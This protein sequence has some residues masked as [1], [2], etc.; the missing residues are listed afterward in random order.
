MKKRVCLFLSLFFLLGFILFVNISCFAQEFIIR[1][2]NSEKIFAVSGNDNGSLN[3]VINN[4][5]AGDNQLIVQNN[6]FSKNLVNPNIND[7]ADSTTASLSYVENSYIVEFNGLSISEKSAQIDDEINKLKAK[8]EL[9]E[10]MFLLQ[11]YGSQISGKE[12]EK[13][14]LGVDYKN[15]L[16]NEHANALFDIQDRIEKSST[17][18]SVSKSVISGKLTAFFRSFLALTG[19][20]ISEPDAP[21]EKEFYN[22]L[23][24]VV[25]N[26]TPQ[27]AEE[28][29]K[30]S[31]V[32]SVIQNRKV[33]SELMNSVPLI[34]AN[35]VW[36]LTDESGR[37]IT[38]ENI[39]I[40]IIDTGIDYTHED[41]GGGNNTYLD[42][43]FSKIN[44]K[45][46]ALEFPQYDQNFDFKDNQVAYYSKNKIY[47]YS[48]DDKNFTEFIPFGENFSIIRMAFENNLIAY[49]ASDETGNV[50]LYFFNTQT[51]QNKKISGISSIGYVFVSNE[52]IIYSNPVGGHTKI[53]IYDPISSNSEILAE[54]S[55]HNLVYPAVNDDI[56]AYSISRV[57]GDCYEKIGV[58][59]I[60]SKEKKYVN[61]TDLGVVFDT[62]G[63]LILFSEC[64]PE[65]FDSQWKT[66]HLY[67]TTNQED[68]TL[69]FPDF[70]SNNSRVES[71]SIGGWTEKGAIGDGVVYFSKDVGANKIVA[72]DLNLTKYSLINL[73]KNS[74]EIHAE[75]KKICFLSGS[76]IYCHD[77]NSSYDYSTPTN[78]FNN[79][80][81]GGHDFVDNDEDP[82]D[83]YG[84]GTHVAG[85]AAGTGNGN[86]KGVAPGALLY[87]YKVLDSSGSGSWGNVIAAI[88]RSVDP[89][90]DGNF[91]DHLDIISLSLGGDG[92]PDD[93][94][95]RA[96][97]NAV[98][99]GVVATISAG[100]SGPGFETIGSPGTSRKAIT[101]GAS[102]D[103]DNL[104]SFSSRGYVK[105]ID[106]NG[107]IN[108]LIKPDV[109]A[110]GVDICS[111]KYGSRWESN[112]CLDNTHVSISGTSMAAPHVA[113]AVAL[114]KQAHPDWSPE[115]IKSQLQNTAKNVKFSGS[116][117]NKEEN[118]FS[119]GYGRIDVFDAVTKETPYLSLEVKTNLDLG[120]LNI[121]PSIIGGNISKYAVYYKRLVFNE[122]KE[123]YSG[124]DINNLERSFNLS[125]LDSGSLLFKLSVED[126]DGNIFYNENFAYLD[127][128]Q[129]SLSSKNGYISSEDETI[130]VN[131]KNGNYQTYEIYVSESDKVNSTFTKVYESENSLV[132]GAIVTVNLGNLNDGK[133][134][135]ELRAKTGS[136]VWVGSIPVSIVIMKNLFGGIIQFSEFQSPSHLSFI[137]SPGFE[138][139]IIFKS[140]NWVPIG[141]GWNRVYPGLEIWN[142]EHRENLITY[143]SSLNKG[144]NSYQVYA[145]KGYGIYSE[146]NDYIVVE[147]AAG[148]Y[149]SEGDRIGII[150]K[151]L[152]YQY[153]WPSNI[154]ESQFDDWLPSPSSSYNSN[155]YS[156]HSYEDSSL[157]DSN[158]SDYFKSQ[159]FNIAVH[160]K[161]G[162]RIGLFSIKSF[163]IEDAPSSYSYSL[164]YPKLLFASEEDSKFGVIYSGNMDYVNDNGENV[165]FKWADFNVFDLNT[166]QLIKS[167]NLSGIIGSDVD[168]ITSAISGDIDNDNKT[169]IILGYKS[170]NRTLYNQNTYDFRIYHA[171]FLI[172]D[173]EGNQ[174]YPLISFE[175]YTLDNEI[176]L[177]EENGKKYIIAPLSGTWATGSIDKL[178]V[179]DLNKN[180]IFNRPVDYY[181]RIGNAISGDI[182]NDNKTEI[183]YFTTSRFW[184]GDSKDSVRTSQVRILDLNNNLKK[185]IK[186]YSKDEFDSIYQIGLYENSGNTWLFSFGCSNDIE[187][188]CKNVSVYG[189]DLGY[190]YNSSKMFWPTLGKNIQ[191]NNCYESGVIKDIISFLNLPSSF[192]VNNSIRVNLS[193]ENSYN[194][195]KNVNYSVYLAKCEFENK[196]E[197]DYV[198]IY[199]GSI[200]IAPNSNYGADLD[201]VVFEEG[202]YIVKTVVSGEE[203]KTKQNYYLFSATKSYISIQGDIYLN[204]KLY[205]NTSNNIR[206]LVEN[207]GNKGA[208]VEVSLYYEKGDCY[209][210]CN[211]LILVGKANLSLRK[212]SYNYLEFEWVPQELGEFSFILVLNATNESL[213]KRVYRTANVFEEGPDALIY[214]DYS[215]YEREYFEGVDSNLSLII[216][217]QGSEDAANLTVSAYEVKY[218]Y[219]KDQK[220]KV[221]YDLISSKQIDKLKVQETRH[222]NLSWIPSSSDYHAISFNITCPKDIDLSNNW[223][224]NYYEVLKNYYD[225]GI[226]E[227]S[228]R[229]SAIIDQPSSILVYAVNLGKKVKNYNLSLYLEGRFI[230]NRIVNTSSYFDGWN[231]FDLTFKNKGKRNIS[232]RIEI[233][234]E[235]F[236]LTNNYLE[237]YPYIYNLTT[238]NLTIKDSSSNLINRV[239]YFENYFSQSIFEI[240]GSKNIT[241]VD[242]SETGE[243]FRF[244]I[245]D[246]YG[247][248]TEND[249]E[250]SFFVLNVFNITF[251]KELEVISEYYDKLD[252]DN[253]T[254]YSVFANK[255][256]S[257]NYNN[258]FY[259]VQ[260]CSYFSGLGMVNFDEDYDV[261]YCSNFDFSSKNC[262]NLWNI[263]RISVIYRSG[264][265]GYCLV[266]AYSTDPAEAFALSLISEKL[267]GATTNLSEINEAEIDNLTFERVAHGNINFKDKVYISRLRGNKALLKSIK[268]APRSISI[269][270]EILSELADIPAEITFKNIIF[271]NPKILYNGG[272]CNSSICGIPIYDKE[273][274]KLT[275]NVSHFSEFEVVEGPYC[276]DG[277]CSN[278]ETCSSCVAD[279]IC[280]PKLK[281]DEVQVGDGSC[282]PKWNCSWSAC[283]NSFQDL[284]CVDLYKCK[285]VPQN[286]LAKKPKG[287]QACILDE[288]CEDNDKDGY[289]T[290]PDCR[291]LDTDDNDPAVHAEIPKK[292]TNAVSNVKT[293]PSEFFYNYRYILIGAGAVITL[294]IITFIFF[295]FFRKRPEEEIF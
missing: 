30:S 137:N 208:K 98:E 222:I 189:I 124:S 223:D 254:Y 162:E 13:E 240:N 250:P 58:Y 109:V 114:I 295:K 215:S 154:K 101:V 283:E 139:N 40:G 248:Y 19:F 141:N 155:I 209:N 161:Y 156:L 274:N 143:G 1:E 37:S 231:D 158:Y 5:S 265:S 94:V 43:D 230:E 192:E 142:K 148:Y 110:P 273:N 293:E 91:S 17:D 133:Y 72:Y 75:G 49:F 245:L 153:S 200:N 134:N 253:H 14:K 166:N 195:N 82:M 172:L 78:V 242:F 257:E 89:N 107:T 54:D 183:I 79:K 159:V 136:G 52:K 3:N 255:A 175:G 275:L 210:N 117:V 241:S 130:Q 220:E 194:L 152:N 184:T 90:Q 219:S 168:Y 205:L 96:I 73:F 201:L 174:K 224:T 169:E 227:I 95:S 284:I 157:D 225:I 70:N 217:N 27:Q 211:N 81:V 80:V 100:N 16:K 118:L 235:D 66:F 186:F 131:V 249:R 288:I 282:V 97:D 76:D 145:P 11:S 294:I 119:I 279:C 127:N 29:K 74:A 179:F 50:A 176:S 34:N 10:R 132:N 246:K 123:L 191:R 221:K 85:I 26:I 263:S 213:V 198:E 99:K 111:S 237:V 252:Y 281:K 92:N 206:V 23:N 2:G 276:G 9:G 171:N 267:D 44:L 290:G 268:I 270:T 93:P 181:E 84:H 38:G 185:D 122:W 20:V 187:G 272:N 42:R 278:S 126:K 115:K 150:D 121:T 6:Q 4:F 218:D 182:D 236:N 60:T 47:I 67:N 196:E 55:E 41:L 61:V 105:W 251:S 128:I 212:E 233:E 140:E 62:D 28:I 25:L 188:Q 167:V 289:G 269:D 68:V 280:Q 229:G 39:T 164:A 57:G 285:Y 266:E 63:E 260:P 149:R 12:K 244:G 202:N 45:S 199:N 46:L 271:R 232:A 262:L 103:Y 33:Y 177:T 277:N 22:V 116:N 32:K 31:Y 83:D 197:C 106:D 193:L 48:F 36:N 234:E 138:K 88:E 112:K 113:G 170:F 214:S 15:Q 238:I 292:T 259:L 287:T 18:S 203:I 86:L 291:G 104:A 247:N 178:Y 135:L 204:S 144:T 173:F 69:R 160:D 56:I 207:S 65:N 180:F 256:S 87:A 165:D 77:Y 163:N 216:Y 35:N 146:G 228:I 151:N 8:K 125:E 71:Y 286:I 129:L 258:V 108:Y 243:K 226:S 264:N 102:N 24:G 147:D 120:I 64:N 21:V 190:A 59:N 51:M 7:L 53:L 261:V 239:G